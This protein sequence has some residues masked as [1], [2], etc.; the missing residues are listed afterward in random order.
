MRSRWRLIL[1]IAVSALFISIAVQG[2]DFDQFFSH[3][4]DA[5]YVWL[6]PGIL[7]YFMGV[8]ART[9]RWHYMLRHIQVIPMKALFRVVCIGYMG[10]NIYP[11]R[12]GEILRSYVLKRET[13]VPMS[14][15]LATVIIERLFDG[16]TMLLFVFVALPFVNL[17]EGLAEYQRFVIGFT[18]LF[19]VALF[20]FLFLATRPSIARSLYTPLV[21]LIL[22]Q[23]FQEKVLGIAERFLMGLESL[24]RG[25][26]IFM[27][28]G[29]SVL[30]WLFETGKYWFVMHAFDFS[31]SFFTLM[32]MNGVV[33]LMT[34]IPAAPGYA[35]TFDLPGIRIL[36]GA[37]VPQ[38]IATAY[39]LVLHV[40]L[41]L[42]IT[43]LGAFY[44]WR[45]HISLSPAQ[46]EIAL[47][48]G[49]S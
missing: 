21:G 7:V 13:D 14:S 44:L 27:I 41:W 8:W 12:A 15:S 42:P 30:V 38:P 40:A 39:T 23:R 2:L 37:G 25:R 49:A 33:N 29:T 31:V 9:W 3:L 32:L 16:L 24:A 6:L 36:V 26:E 47:E 4:K 46:R 10:N 1:G 43:L 19:L 18:V 20:V 11:A 48:T 35:G 17:P 28:F 34:T 45:S 22:P 5:E